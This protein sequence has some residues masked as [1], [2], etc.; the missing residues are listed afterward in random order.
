VNQKPFRSLI[1]W[2]IWATTALVVYLTLY[3]DTEIWSF[4]ETDPSRI[5]WLILGMFL[6]GVAASFVLTII[7]TK[8]AYRATQ[9]EREAR[10]GGLNGIVIKAGERIADRFFRSLKAT[11]DSRGQPDVERLLHVELAVLERISHMIETAGSLLITLGLIGTVMGLTI[12]LSGLTGSIEALGQD[13]ELLM[14]GLR[15]A[16]GGMGTAFYNTLLGAVLGGV[17]LRVFAQI[18]QHGV[19]A[20]HDNLMRICLVWCSNEYS[21]TM[22]RDV[23]LLNDELRLLDERVNLL[24]GSFHDSFG[25]LREFRQEMQQFMQG[26][27][28]EGNESLRHLVQEHRAYCDSLREEMRL[29]LHLRRP[30]WVRLLEV[31]RAPRP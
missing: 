6:L 9:L 13:Q 19:E 10:E 28:S 18:N 4:M 5:T 20:L 7:I 31:F 17:L 11:V 12:T 29:L 30:W 8:E 22:E 1:L 25:A 3:S 14:S 15:Q 23:R 26:S 16:M 27:P 24:K 21:M 2:T